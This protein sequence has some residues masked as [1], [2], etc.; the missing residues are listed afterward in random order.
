MHCV[1]FIAR[2]AS[3]L[4]HIIIIMSCGTKLKCES[5]EDG[6]KDDC[7]AWGSTS[8]AR[9]SYDMENVSNVEQ[10]N[11]RERF[12]TKKDAHTPPQTC[13]YTFL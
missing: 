12:R 2:D 13:V 10:C 6:S 9:Q 7:M 11:C 3:D 4:V 1:K 5:A 8:S